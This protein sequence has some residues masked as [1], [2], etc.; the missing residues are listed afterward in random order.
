MSTAI[1]LSFVAGLALL[2]LAA[3]QTAEQAPEAT[4]ADAQPG[5]QAAEAPA[6]A[7]PGDGR[8]TSEDEYRT[9]IVG[10][11]L[12]W[13]SGSATHHEDGS[14]TGNVGDREMT[15]TWS[16]QDGFYCRS[17]RISNTRVPDDCQILI[18]SGDELTVIRDGG[19][20]D[21]ATFRIEEAE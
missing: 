15:G 19:M 4:P 2:A 3:C 20:G 1:R 14:I 16:W 5:E 8:I 11:R 13:E 18:V 12:V 7:S 6:A 17:I 9:T 10:K 21:I